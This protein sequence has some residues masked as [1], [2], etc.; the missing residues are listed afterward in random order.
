MEMTAAAPERAL[1]VECEASV[2]ASGERPPI[3][4]A[5]VPRE[6]EQLDES[7]VPEARPAFAEQRDAGA[8]RF[9]RRVA[10][11]VGSLDLRVEL[12]E[13]GARVALAAYDGDGTREDDNEERRAER[14]EDDG[15]AAWT[16]SRTS[17]ASSCPETPLTTNSS[18]P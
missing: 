9:E 4:V 3:H 7:A 14:A 16:A 17:A 11:G 1:A 15:H 2:E 6:A 13:A 10:V 12:L 8:A 18:A 5:A